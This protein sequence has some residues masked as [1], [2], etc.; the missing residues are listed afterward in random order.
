MAT[1]LLVLVALAIQF[2]P[3]QQRRAPKAAAPER[4]CGAAV[5]HDWFED[6][7]IDGTYETRCY[8]AALAKVP[9]DAYS[10]GPFLIALNENL[11]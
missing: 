11:E 8:R 3:H 5:L 10:D 6:A 1:A 2:W 7:R 4:E 9:D